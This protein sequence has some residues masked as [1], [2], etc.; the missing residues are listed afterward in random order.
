MWCASQWE[1]PN[2][3]LSASRQRAGGPMRS[4]EGQH[5]RRPVARLVGSF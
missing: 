3:R 2:G 1:M 4:K 5:L